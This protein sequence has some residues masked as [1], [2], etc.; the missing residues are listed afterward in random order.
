MR[1]AFCASEVVPF[2][3]TG[4]L[5]DVCG[6]LPPALEQLGHEIVIITPRYGS[7]GGPASSPVV[8]IGQN[9]KVYFVEH[10]HY[11]GRDGLYGDINGDY[12]DNLERFSYL[13]HH[14]LKILKDVGFKPD[15]VHCHDWHTAL[16][17][18]LLKT[19]YDKDPFYKKTRSVLTIHNLA[20]QGVFP[21]EQYS[22]LGV[23][24]N[25]FNTQGFEFYHQVNV[26][27]GGINF[28]DAIT[29][30]SPCYSKEMQTPE[31]G[32]SLDGVL[33]NHSG[34]IY[35]ILN[36]LDYEAWKPQEDPF[37][38][39]PFTAG[40][41]D[42]KLRNKAFL[43]ESLGLNV[44]PKRPLFGFVA[45]LCHQKGVDL[46]LQ[47]I[48]E[49]IK[50][51]GQLA[52]TGI[53]E[54]K[55][56]RQLEECAKEHPKNVGIYLKFEERIAHQIYAG[57]D[58][59]L[60]PSVY[61]PCGLGQMIALRYGSIPIVYKT[62]GLAD[63]ISLYDPIHHTGN[64]FLFTEYTKPAFVKAVAEAVKVYADHKQME[65][66]VS[67]GMRHR[68]TWEK[69]AKEYVRVYEKCLSLD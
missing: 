14:T 61:E 68:F 28:S 54:R 12:R 57:S 63:T 1:I 16:L 17:P 49:I 58:F 44:D 37:L 7:A 26:L 24:G 42:N 15:I 3:K 52:L 65:F 30:V 46:I 36:G 41:W 2:A 13:C 23:D 4:G 32:C 8:R 39:V 43:Q 48:P 27:K 21:R 62:G 33:R 34:D 66:L 38:F 51:G 56:H 6:S 45:R 40:D 22:I 59:F 31:F 55:Y 9:V 20:Y 25:L 53:G 67:H 5:A 19:K 50:M 18:A 60:M 64:G 69:S 47:A 10:K 35:G 29:T 11:F